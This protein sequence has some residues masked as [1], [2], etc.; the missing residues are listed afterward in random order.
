ME[1]FYKK[2]GKVY[3][4]YF[5]EEIHFTSEGLFH[6]KFK[7]KFKARVTKDAQTRLRLIPTAIGIIKAS[8]TL[9][10][11]DVRQNFEFRFVNSR[12]ELALRTVTY[13][14]LIAI[15]DNVKAKVILKQI[16]NEHKTFLSV[17]PLFK[18]KT[19]PV[20]DDSL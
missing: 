8:H 11:K 20:G 14:E 6:L 1:E 13:Y 4:P 19:P 16:E 17:I 3:C 15:I 12:K 18:Q 9:Q 7:T 10:G 5:K 2:I